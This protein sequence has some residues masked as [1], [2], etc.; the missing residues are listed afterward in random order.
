MNKDIVTP[1]QNKGKSI[2]ETTIN[3][4]T[5]ELVI[6]IITD[7]WKEGHVDDR[8]LCGCMTSK[9]IVYT[10]RISVHDLYLAFCRS[11]GNVRMVKANSIIEG[12]ER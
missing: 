2:P 7:T 9:D 5:K 4:K 12:F 10:E 1:I 8:C 11:C 3:T 6:T